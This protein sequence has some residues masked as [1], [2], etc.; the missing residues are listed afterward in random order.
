[1][2]LIQEEAER[3]GWFTSQAS[4]AVWFFGGGSQANSLS[5]RTSGNEGRAPQIPCFE[6]NSC[7]GLSS[8]PRGRCPVK[9]D[10][11]FLPRPSLT[12]HP[13]AGLSILSRPNLQRNREW[14]WRLAQGELL[15]AWG[16]II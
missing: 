15:M 16:R 4:P 14:F 8:H 9:S 6:P 5:G 10:L 11:P 13:S 7:L 12:I 2:P 3:W 1:M